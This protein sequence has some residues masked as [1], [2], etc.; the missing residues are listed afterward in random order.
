MTEE[1]KGERKRLT[2]KMHKF[3]MNFVQKWAF[4]PKPEILLP[5][6]LAIG[7]LSKIFSKMKLEF[8]MKRAL[9]KLTL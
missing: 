6:R 7:V 2:I 5:L 8:Q 3:A 4:I 1:Y 9:I